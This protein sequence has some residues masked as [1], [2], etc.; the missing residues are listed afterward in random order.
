MG[1][2]LL[3]FPRRLAIPDL[4]LVLEVLALCLLNN[5]VLPYLL[6]GHACLGALVFQVDQEILK[7]P[8]FL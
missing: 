2:F 4:P 5:L 3:S 7:F 6:G 1:P 8:F